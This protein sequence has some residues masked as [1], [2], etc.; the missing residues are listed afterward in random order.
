MFYLLIRK[1]SS[2]DIGSTTYS[3][4]TTVEA[5]TGKTIKKSFPTIEEAQTYVQEIVSKG[6]MGLND[7]LVIKGVV[8]TATLTL[9]EE[10]A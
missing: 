8:V 4:M 6:E 9:A 7:F 3:F 1:Q 5:D 10:T 2:P